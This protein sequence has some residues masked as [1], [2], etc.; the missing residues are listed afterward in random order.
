MGHKVFF[1]FVLSWL[2]M[3]NKPHHILLLG[4]DKAAEARYN[5]LRKLGFLGFLYS[6]TFERPSDETHPPAT[7]VSQQVP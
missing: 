4:L 7:D 1:G 5:T 6:Q 2:M 3:D